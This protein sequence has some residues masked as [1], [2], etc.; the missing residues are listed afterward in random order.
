MKI[1]KL[2]ILQ[3]KENNRCWNNFLPRWIEI[4]TLW[5]FFLHISTWIINNINIKIWRK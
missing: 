4:V 3:L 5:V 1:Q 2:F